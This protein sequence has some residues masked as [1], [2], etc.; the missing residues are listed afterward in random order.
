MA[1]RRELTLLETTLP[2]AFGITGGV[3]LIAGAFLSRRPRRDVA[4]PVEEPAEEPAER[5]VV[6]GMDGDPRDR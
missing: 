3:A 4:E 1:G 6:P 5:S 2:L